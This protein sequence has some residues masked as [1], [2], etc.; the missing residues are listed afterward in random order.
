MRVAIAERGDSSWVL[1]ADVMQGPISVQ[2]SDDLRATG[3]RMLSNGLRELPIV[4]K[5]GIVIGMV[6]ESA[7]A[8]V[9]LKGAARAEGEA[10]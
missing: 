4:S 1:A 6:T 10:T 7:L 3:E 5:D 8:G 9:Y 2:P